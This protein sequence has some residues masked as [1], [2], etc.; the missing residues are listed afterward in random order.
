[1]LT[2][3]DGRCF[4]VLRFFFRLH[5]YTSVAT[6]SSP[7]ISPTMAAITIPAM[8]P[9]GI[10]DVFDPEFVP[11]DVFVP[12]LAL[13]AS[14]QADCAERSE[15]DASIQSYNQKEHISP[16]S[17]CW[18]CVMFGAISGLRLEEHR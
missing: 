13:L 14:I 11:S 3:S 1:M 5:K 4:A 15:P 9:P 18:Y 12:Q 2:T 6:P 10:F 8:T 17:L 7:T 16:G